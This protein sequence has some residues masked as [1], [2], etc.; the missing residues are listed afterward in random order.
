MKDCHNL[1][2]NYIK[3]EDSRLDDGYFLF[4]YRGDG[5]I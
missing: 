2:N 1:M 4:L 5:I 3:N